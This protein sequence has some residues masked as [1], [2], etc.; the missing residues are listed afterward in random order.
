[1][2]RRF[3]IA[4][5][6]LTAVPIAAELAGLRP[7]AAEALSQTAPAAASDRMSMADYKKAH[8]GNSVVTIDV[9]DERA[10]EQAHIPGAL[11]MPLSSIDAAAAKK[12]KSLGKPVVAYCA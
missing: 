7:V 8:A 10:Y 4:V 1:M 5:G 2:N 6:V 12:L 9:R 3:L 11:L